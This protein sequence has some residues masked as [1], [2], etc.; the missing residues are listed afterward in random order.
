MGIDLTNGIRTGC[1]CLF[2]FPAWVTGFPHPRSFRAASGEAAVTQGSCSERAHHG[3]EVATSQTW[4]FWCERQ[5]GR[6]LPKPGACSARHAHGPGRAVLPQRRGVYFV[7]FPNTFE[8]ETRVFAGLPAPTLGNTD[9]ECRELEG[10]ARSPRFRDFLLI[11]S[12]LWLPLSDAQSIP[13]FFRPVINLMF[14]SNIGLVKYVYFSVAIKQ[15]MRMALDRSACR[16]LFTSLTVIKVK[17]NI[18]LENP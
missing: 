9:R 7:S 1:F 2:I 11:P 18:V 17:W 8:R 13:F 4:G 3:Q 14:S 15:G 12:S 10:A 6:S 16:V 5:Q